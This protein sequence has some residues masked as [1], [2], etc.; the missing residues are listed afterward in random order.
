MEINI[1]KLKRQQEGVQKWR[2]S[3]GKGSLF[4]EVGVGKTFTAILIALEMYKA[5]SETTII[6][7]VPSDPL[8]QQWIKEIEI[9]LN[10]HKDKIKIYTRNQII[11]NN[12]EEEVDLIIIDEIHEFTNNQ[13][14][15][16]VQGNYIKY[17]YILGLTGTYY[18]ADKSH[19]NLFPYAPIVDR[20]TE[21][22][23][24]EKGFISTIVE[25]NLGIEFTKSELEKYNYYNEEID[26]YM[27]VFNKDF[28][29]AQKCI[30]GKDAKSAREY[31]ASLHG[32]SHN[33]NLK[34]LAKKKIDAQ[35]N[36]SKIFKYAVD[37]AS[38][39]Q[40][41]MRLCYTAF[42]KIEPSV[43]LCKK[44]N[45]KTIIFSQNTDFADRLFF[46][47]NYRLREGDLLTALEPTQ[48]KDVCSI[49]HSNI[50]TRIEIINGKQKKVGKVTLKKRALKEIEESKT[51][52]FITSSVMDRGINIV[53]LRMAINISS[54]RDANQH[55]QRK[56]RINRLENENPDIKVL[57]VNVYVKNSVEESWLKN[58]QRG[59][60]NMIKYV[61]NVDDIN[62]KFEE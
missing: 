38:I 10:K 57:M 32:W 61:S 1:N 29:L 31:V 59:S 12:I 25:Y 45:V 52:V 8:K 17:K 26:K 50:Q 21:E 5:N 39:V 41:R 35:Y 44:F 51:R 55:T 36:P 47:I 58:K 43:Q 53:D 42:N 48:V 6:V 13:G 7:V 30:K 14:L 16:I 56:G 33:L 2:F 54:T 4:Y 18:K 23:A 34:D 49:Y 28:L 27:N 40:Q 46:E 60:K 19:R 3:G 62:H 37:F 11:I 20:I 15:G 22:E 9:H 24:R